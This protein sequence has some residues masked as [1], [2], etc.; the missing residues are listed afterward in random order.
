MRNKLSETSNVSI[1]TGVNGVYN[2]CTLPTCLLAVGAKGQSSCVH[3]HH[4]TVVK[5][6]NKFSF[7]NNRCVWYKLIVS[8]EIA[9]FLR[10]GKFELSCYRHRVYPYL[11]DYIDN[12][13]KVEGKQTNV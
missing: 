5:K 10:D 13:G 2:R 11:L 6:M 3:Q 1:C 8:N 7:L 12:I 9:E 4:H